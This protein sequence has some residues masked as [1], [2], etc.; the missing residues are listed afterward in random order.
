MS[1]AWLGVNDIVTE[2]TFRELKNPRGTSSVYDPIGGT[3]PSAD[4]SKDCVVMNEADGRWENVDCVSSS[5]NQH[6]VLCRIPSINNFGY[7]M[8]TGRVLFPKRKMLFL[9]KITHCKYAQVCKYLHI[10][11]FW[12]ELSCR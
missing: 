11:S 10:S 7:D 8:I 12:Y 6:D 3:T 4:D 9:D 5:T 2:G 1:S